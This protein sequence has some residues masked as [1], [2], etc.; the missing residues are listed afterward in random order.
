MS[1]RW[2]KRSLVSIGVSIC[3]LTVVSV[4][5]ISSV[6][7]ATYTSAEQ[8]QINKQRKMYHKISQREY[9]DHNS[10]AQ[11]PS[12]KK[13]LVVGKLSNHYQTQLLASL[14]FYRQIEGLPTV[15]YGFNANQQAQTAAAD[16][17]AA[18]N[19]Q[20]GL[21]GITRPDV[22]SQRQW[23][24]GQ[25]ITL[26]SNIGEMN[27][28]ER[29]DAT[30]GNYI[31]DN[32]NV[33]GNNTGH[34]AWLLSPIVHSVGIGVAHRPNATFAYS[35]IYFTDQAQRAVTPNR[36]VVINYPTTGV[37]PKEL[38]TSDVKN[39]PVYWSSAFTMEQG[40][41]GR[42]QV[43]V[44]DLTAKRTVN[45]AH[46]NLDHTNHF[47]QFASIITYRP[48]LKIVNGHQYR[49]RL[50]GLTQYPKGYQYEFKP[51]SLVRSASH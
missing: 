34:R 44:T 20:H 35:D 40:T 38:L 32:F 13:H 33:E 10:Y 2:V 9:D 12:F 23:Q 47:G 28:P 1:K 5:H 3:A 11:R 17:A 29:L 16:M 41:T 14:N 37:F 27:V 18:N 30:M 45:A 43:Q 4:M 24:E 46:V 19:F 42:V 39:R 22:V 21:K 7:A 49:V 48:S 26:N 36:A 31:R 8:R 25:Q 15:Y 51:F 6:S 50:T